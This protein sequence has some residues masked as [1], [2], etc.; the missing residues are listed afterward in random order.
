MPSVADSKAEA[1]ASRALVP[2]AARRRDAG[3]DVSVAASCAK[4]F[5]SEMVSRLADRNMQVHGG[6]G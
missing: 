6:A 1:R 5:A 2:G 3:G 4:M